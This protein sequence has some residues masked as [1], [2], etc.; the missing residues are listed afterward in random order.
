MNYRDIRELAIYQGKP[1]ASLY[2]ACNDRFGCINK[3]NALCLDAA[4]KIRTMYSFAQ[5]E[6]L[7]KKLESLYSHIPV[8]P[9]IKSIALF[10][11]DSIA[12]AYALPYSVEDTIYVAD[13]F[14]LDIIIRRLGR[15]VR[16]WVLVIYHGRPFLFDGF[17]D[18][19]LEIVH[20]HYLK[21]SEEQFGVDGLAG[22]ICGPNISLWGRNCRYTTPEEFVRELDHSLIH[23]IESD[24][25]P[26]VCCGDVS[27]VDAFRTHSMY[28]DRVLLSMP[29]TH[30][31]D[32]E[33]LQAKV[34]PLAQRG[35]DHLRKEMLRNLQ[36]AC[37][38]NLCARGLPEVWRALHEGRVQFMCLEKKYEPILGEL[39]ISD[40]AAFS[41]MCHDG[42]LKN[43]IDALLEI[44]LREAVPFCWYE[45]AALSKYRHTAAIVISGDQETP[46]SS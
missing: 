16:Y 23:F 46:V 12:W 41:Q 15:A 1:A 6:A 27:S 30:L 21:T 32:R 39:P 22:K 43:G 40:D 28:G 14:M 19:L 9:H 10:V 37:A 20:R 24:P 42:S 11:N 34:W 44:A 18:V 5:G 17:E 29:L 38:A 13:R 3:I 26:I 33:D 4:R 36:E 45:P 8:E 25:L 31:P 7:A 35:Y 2:I